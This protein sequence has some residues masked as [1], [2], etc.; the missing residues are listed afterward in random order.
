MRRRHASL[1]RGAG[2]RIE[3]PG[4]DALL[5]VAA[6]PGA[7]GS[8]QLARY[9]HGEILVRTD[10][11]IAQDLARI[12]QRPAAGLGHGFG[13]GD[14]L[15]EILCAYQR[16]REIGRASCWERVWK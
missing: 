6:E 11:R 4:V 14:Q 2:G 5:D 16:L 9:L 8:Q 3:F 1:R 15:V 10:V 13:E 12:V 7:V